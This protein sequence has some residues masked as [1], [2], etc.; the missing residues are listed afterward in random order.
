MLITIEDVLTPSEVTAAR[1]SIAQVS[2]QDGRATAGGQAAQAKNNEQ[3]PETA[4]QL[5]A[6][7]RQVLDA[8]Q[9]SALFFSAALPLK[10]LPPMFNRYG[11]ASNTYGA[12]VDSALQQ[13][14]GS[15]GLYVRSDISATLF[16]SDPANYDGGTLTIHDSFGAHGI[17]LKAGS[18]VLY[19]SSSVH[20]VSPVTRGERIACFLF[21]QSLVRDAEQR[22]LLYDMD[23]ALLQLRHKL[24]ETP[25]LVQLTGSYHNLLR[26]WAEPA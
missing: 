5:P 14:P 1:Q 9:R 2:W 8:L 25:E 4:A 7:R 16:L 15:G 6:L 10:I 24:G 11:G 12:H 13:A 21:I 19:P 18:L 23:M 22:R 17:K 20:S 26:R 3:I